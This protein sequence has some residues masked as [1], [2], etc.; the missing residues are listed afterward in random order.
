MGK[1]A[2]ERDLSMRDGSVSGDFTQD[3][4]EIPDDQLGGISSNETFEIDTSP[5]DPFSESI[6]RDI[7]DKHKRGGLI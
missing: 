4:L 7:R 1:W 3:Q 2:H 6:E 5:I